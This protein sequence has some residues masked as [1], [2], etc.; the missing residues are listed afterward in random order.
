MV[1]FL[2]AF[3]VARLSV[4]FW[5]IESLSWKA[6][7]ERIGIAGYGGIAFVIEVA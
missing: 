3:L 1:A 6:L 5:E 2:V 7:G 4:V